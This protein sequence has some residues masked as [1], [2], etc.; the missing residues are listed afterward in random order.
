MQFSQFSRD[1]SHF[2]NFLLVQIG[3]SRSGQ[4]QFFQ[5]GGTLDNAA[6]RGEGQLE[7]VHDQSA[8]EGKMS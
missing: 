1:W 7:T 5:A 4:V 2:L 8:C 6:Q 3:E